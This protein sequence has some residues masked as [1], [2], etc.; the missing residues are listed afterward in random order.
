[1]GRAAVPYHLPSCVGDI[2]YG[3]GLICYHI[4]AVN[5]RPY[6][7]Y[8]TVHSPNKACMCSVLFKFSSSIG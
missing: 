5:I 4:T 6:A 3:L 1:M 8:S 7:V 2:R